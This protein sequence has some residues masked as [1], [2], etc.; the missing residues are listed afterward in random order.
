MTEDPGSSGRARRAVPLIAASIAVIVVAGVFYIGSVVPSPTATP[1]PPHIP[2]MSGPYTATYDFLTP[3]LGWALVLDYGHFSTTLSTNF[4]VFKTTDGATNWQQQYK[5]SAQGGQTYLHFFDG[6][7]GFAYAGF[8]YR[9]EDGGDH[10]Q[11]VEVPGS[12][13]YVTFASPTLG[14]AESSEVGS[15]RLYVTRDAGL[16][17]TLLPSK[18]PAAS[19][20]QIQSSAFRE[21]GEG[22]LGAGSFADPTVYQTVDGGAS[23]RT[24]TTPLPSAVASGPSYETSVKLVPGGG[25]LVLV[26]DETARLLGAFSSS[27]RGG[28]WREVAFPVA[29]KTPDVLS[30][31]DATHWWLLQAGQLYKTT[32]AGITWV[33]ASPVGLPDGWS[34]QAARAID[35]QHAWWSMVSS[36]SSTLSALAVTK[37]GGSHW[38]T[39]NVPQPPPGEPI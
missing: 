33:H 4:W 14:W 1:R 22:W 39:V 11:T 7:H 23:W 20:L 35:A 17:W 21:S 16:T 31:V 5:G 36:A 2:V 15:Q 37:D 28:S 30:L 32:D 9:T 34:L 24:I 13:P 29:V 12:T 27:D 8:S 25:V 26:S 18:R 3:S 10:W 19:V 6:Q 38:I